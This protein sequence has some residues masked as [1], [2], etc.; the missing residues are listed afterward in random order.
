[1]SSTRWTEPSV[2]FAAVLRGRSVFVTGHTG[3]KGSWLS[4]WLDTLGATVTGFALDP[5]TRPSNFEESSIAAVLARDVRGDIRD[6]EAL[7]K[8]LDI[9]QPDVIL[10]LA[11]RTVVR[12][13]Y[14]DPL[15]TIS[16]NV[17]GTATLL[18]VVRMR[19]KPCAVVVVSTDKCYANDESGRAFAEGDALGGDDPY[20]ASKG[21]VELVTHAYRQSFFPPEELDRHG[22]AVCTARAGNVIGGGDW[23]PDGLVADVMRALPLGAPV[24]IRNPTAVRPWQHVL[25]PL[26]GYLTLASKLLGPRAADYC[27][28]W[29]F[30]PEDADLESVA[31]VVDQ[32]VRGWGSGTWQS[33][34]DENDPHEANVLRLS[35]TRARKELGWRSRWS[36]S[37]A[38]DRTVGWYR[39][40]Y[41]DPTTARAA[42]LADI[43][44]YSR[45]TETFTSPGLAAVPDTRA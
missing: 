24:T 41:S 34:T 13:G 25:E 7:R 40:Y 14:T 18:D 39:Q 23:T 17:M 43:A 33:R 16:A 42:C 37:E 11:A 3:F 9:S 30:G 10:H 27:T 8:A 31:Q 28:A 6:G 45:T 29:N 44:A 20:S 1:M 22:I 15:D 19:G 12:E 35:S 4:L 32:L 38:V 26:A 2:S 21:A 5:P 36:T